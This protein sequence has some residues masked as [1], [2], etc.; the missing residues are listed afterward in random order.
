[1]FTSGSTGPWATLSKGMVATSPVSGG[2]TIFIEPGKYNTQAAF[3]RSGS[4]GNPITIVGDV[5]GAGFRAGGVANPKVGPVIMT[6]YSN[7][8]TGATSFTSPI[9]T[10]TSANVSFIN[11]RNLYVLGTAQGGGVKGAI[12]VTPGIGY[13]CTDWT[14]TDCVVSAGHDSFVNGGC[15]FVYYHPLTNGVDPPPTNFTIDRCTFL[16][17]GSTSWKGTVHFHLSKGTVEIDHNVRI[18]N[19]QIIGG[20]CGVTINTLTNGALTAFPVGLRVQ[21]CTITH[22]HTWGVNL[23]QT[24][25]INVATPLTGGVTNYVYGSYIFGAGVG[26]AAGH[27]SQVVEDGNYTPSGRAAAVVAGANSRTT[28]APLVNPGL[29]RII[30]LPPRPF[31]EPLPISTSPLIGVGSYGTP[32][33]YDIHN[34]QRPDGL[35]SLYPTIGA[36]EIHDNGERNTVYADGGTGAC[37]QLGPGPMSQDRLLSLP[38]SATA[39]SVKVRWDG[40]HGDATKPQAILLP[41]PEI[42]ITAGQTV[43]ATTSY[44]TGGGSSAVPGSY[45]TLT[46]APITPT[47]AG[48]LILRMVSRPAAASGNAY[49]DTIAVS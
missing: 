29:E 11:I 5:D 12:Y 15:A 49:F 8:T 6:S 3:A 2:D 21:N 34:R 41:N 13:T 35:G 7:D 36:H 38:A 37:L 33:A 46:F 30:G 9:A 25:G 48:G 16:S 27:S 26:F 18:R 20:M 14:I 32:S 39:I 22:Y 23:Y 24:S 1:V 43:T 28:G 19:C 17:Y 44:A 42:G 45:E 10:V 40:N 4:A 47:V 31:L